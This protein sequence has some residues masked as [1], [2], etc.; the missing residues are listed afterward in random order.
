MKENAALVISQKNLNENNFPVILRKILFN[1]NL[2][3]DLAKNIKKIMP[4]NSDEKIAN[5]IIKL[6][7]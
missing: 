2:Q 4:K 1:Q 5:I 6:A 7:D 3:N